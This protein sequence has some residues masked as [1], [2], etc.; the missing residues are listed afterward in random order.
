MYLSSF[1]QVGFSATDSK[2]SLGRKLTMGLSRNL[3]LDPYWNARS[4]PDGSWMLFRTMWLGGL[5]TEAVL[6]KLPP[7]PQADVI[8]RSDF[9][10]MT[11]SVSSSSIPATNNVL[12]EFG[13]AENGG[14]EDYFCTSR[15]EACAK[16]AQAGYGMIGDSISGVPCTGSCSVAIPA[17]PGRVLYYRV[18][19]RDSQNRT[20][21]F[22]TPG[23]VLV[24]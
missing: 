13:Y 15:R 11:V 14:I 6:A 9:V 7:F 10:P 12:V 4:L 17:V 3:L 18:V 24:P 23:V 2:G 20:L 21:T 19:Y 1:A 22:S 16:G 8:D 5:R